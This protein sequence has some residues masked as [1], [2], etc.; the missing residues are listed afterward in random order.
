[1]TID[2]YP[3]QALLDMHK[4]WVYCLDCGL[5]I[6]PWD[7]GKKKLTICNICKQVYIQT[8]HPWLKKMLAEHLTS[9][10][11]R[12]FSTKNTFKCKKCGNF[13]CNAKQ[14]K[15]QICKWC[16]LLSTK[17]SDVAIN[18]A[19]CNKT[20]KAKY[21][22]QKVICEDCLVTL[23]NIKS[24]LKYTYYILWKT[25]QYNKHKHIAV[26]TGENEYD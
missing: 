4:N 12:R 7:P 11:K 19:F 13:F 17:K 20:L 5:L 15:K 6:E 18:C 22:S 23:D 2:K 24:A 25:K 14:Q 26:N 21:K 9:T 8:T 16:E 1:M 3:T 10:R